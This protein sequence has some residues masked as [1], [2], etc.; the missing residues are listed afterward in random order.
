VHSVSDVTQTEVHTAEPL[1]PGPSLEDEIA[2]AKLKKCKLP[3]SD[4]VFAE[5]IQVGSEPLLPDIHNLI[6]SDWNRKELP[7]Q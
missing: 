2:I 7:D 5:L 4:R 6:S 1:I 3:G